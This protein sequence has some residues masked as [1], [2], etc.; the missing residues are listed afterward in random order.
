MKNYLKAINKNLTP[1]TSRLPGRNDQVQ[2]NAG[3]FVF[4]ISNEQRFMR[5][6]ILGTEGGT[7]YANEQTQTKLETDF[8]QEFAKQNGARAVQIL[9]DI[10]RDNRAPKADPSLVALAAV[11][12][13][14]DLEARKLAWAALPQIARTGTHLLHFLEFM[15]NFGGW[16][17]LTRD[18][19]ARIYTDMKL[20][21]LALWAVKYKGRDGWTQADALRLA[22][23]KT[24]DPNRN[25]IFKF[26]VDGVLENFGSEISDPALR[27]LEGHLKVANVTSDADAAVLMLE[28]G[29][30]ME[31][32][33][34]NARGAKVYTAALET[35][36]L[37]WLL[38]NLGNLGKHGVL[39]PGNWEMTEKIVA[40]V[41]DLDA[42]VK[43]RIHPIDALKA[44]LVY[45]SGRG[46]RGNG[47][48]K[49]VPQIKDALETAFYMAFRNVQPTN[50]RFLLGI[51]VSGSM[52]CGTVAGVPGLSPNIAAAAMSMVTF[53]SEKN[54]L[55][56][57]FAND[58]R[59]LGISPKDTLEIAMK[60][61][62][63][64]SFGSTDCA[65][66]MVWAAKNNIKTD[67]F[68]VYTDSETWAGKVQP[69]VALE[70]Y[71][72][73]M[74]IA[75]RLVVVGMTATQFSIADPKDSGMLDVVGF[76]GATPNIISG[77]AKGE[78]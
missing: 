51:D 5:F 10:A 52:T 56:Y 62:Q 14:G 72:Q 38:R 44:M 1:Q 63:L 77:F 69:V 61:T 46:V 74:G 24:V 21:K 32:I 15:Q 33:P 58:F 53:R 25:A 29:I 57:G 27:L 59:D 40:R 26:M 19:V 20:E 73:K 78:F 35:N 76:D 6:L 70:Q 55:A 68:V 75:A 8:V 36:G 66:P 54:A 16:G 4:Q 2:N 18:G 17:R 71:R 50:K 28:Y 43:G 49:V 42:L 37:T 23:P 13:L 48:W 60:K 22:H 31:S 3:G 45:G 12:K 67:V 64:S 11:A 9:L 34:T 47:E 65:L 41:T 7:F 39:V 30:P